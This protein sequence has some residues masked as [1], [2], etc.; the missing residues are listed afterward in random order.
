MRS[1]IA[2]KIIIIFIL[3]IITGIA[4]FLI[5]GFALQEVL[6]R[7]VLEKRQ[8]S[9]AV[10]RIFDGYVYW[11]RESIVF[12]EDINFNK[13]ISELEFLSDTVWITNEYEFGLFENAFKYNDELDR[14]IIKARF[15]GMYYPEGDY[16]HMNKYLHQIKITEV[17]DYSN[18]FY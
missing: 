4:W 11:G 9:Q 16:G 6:K 14:R 15:K 8:E 3:I 2:K 5:D 7:W 12:V 10:E 17:I 18:D 1:K 13:E